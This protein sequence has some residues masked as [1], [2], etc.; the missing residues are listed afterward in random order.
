M[1]VLG[2]LWPDLTLFVVQRRTEAALVLTQVVAPS[3]KGNMGG[4]ERG[5]F[6]I[7]FTRVCVCVYVA[8]VFECTL[9]EVA[10]IFKGKP[11]GTICGVQIPLT[12]TRFG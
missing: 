6:P 8:L 9:L 3:E 11:E 4:L 7:L 1:F 2:K 5:W 12:H 10:L